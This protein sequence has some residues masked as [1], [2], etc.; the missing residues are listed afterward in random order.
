VLFR[1]TCDVVLLGEAHFREEKFRKRK[2]N[3]EDVSRHDDGVGDAR[4]RQMADVY[5]APGEM[6]PGADR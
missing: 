1:S 3:R 4:V 2:Q 5:R 6:K